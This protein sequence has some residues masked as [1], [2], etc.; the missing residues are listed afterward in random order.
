M[1]DTLAK[2]LGGQARIKIMRLFLLNGE[3]FFEIEDIINRSRV[4]KAGV[5]KELN[6]L[7]SVDFIKQKTITKEGSRGAKKKV[8]VWILNT[9]FR[10]L[11]PIKDLL[12]DPEVIMQD[13]LVDKIKPIGRIGLLV[14][15]GVFMGKDDSRVDMMMVGDRI[16]KNVLNQVVKGLESEIGKELD[17]VVFDTKEF[18]YRLNMYDKLVFD[19]LDYPHIKLIENIKLSTHSRSK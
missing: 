10:Y 14:V 9:N 8:N 15:S 7:S 11:N 5:R 13:D 18:L 16:K 19:I 2:L 3:Q 6:A 1:I 17:Y 4:Q 12:I